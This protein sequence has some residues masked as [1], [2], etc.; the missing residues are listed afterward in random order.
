MP[1]DIGA[2][3]QQVA[4]AGVGTKLGLALENHNDQRQYEQQQRLQELQIQGQKDM[5][6]YNRN[7]Q[8][9]MWEATNYPAQVNQLKLAGLNPGL[10]YGMGG[11]GGTT[12]G[13]ATGSVSGAEAPKGGHEVI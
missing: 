13:N 5:A 11:G 8:I 4:G 9:K 10:M 1:F 12:V 6:D 3:G 2:L 7:N